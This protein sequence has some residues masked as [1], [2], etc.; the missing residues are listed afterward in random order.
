MARDKIGRNEPCPCGSGLKYKRCCLQTEQPED[1]AKSL[2]MDLREEIHEAMAGDEPADLEQAQA[3]LNEIMEA[4]N[5]RPVDDFHGLSPVQMGRIL[6]APFDSPDLIQITRPL[7]DTPQAPILTLFASIAEAIGERGLKPTAKGN[8]PRQVCRDALQAFT[9]A[10][11]EDETPRFGQLGRE[12]DFPELHVTRVAAEVGG[13]IRKHNRRFILSRHAR[14]VLRDEGLPGIYPELFRAYAEQFNWA[15]QDGY[16]SLPTVQYAGFFMLYLLS[17]YGDDW[18]PG[19]FYSDAFLTAFPMVMDELDRD[20]P[21]DTPEGYVARCV[22]LRA[23]ERF[24]EFLGLA[25]TRHAAG[26]P[27]DILPVREVRKT[28]LLDGFICFNV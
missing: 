22:R 17:Q 4:R 15:Y 1:H 14:A 13:L 9:D 6:N 16:P 5:S 28:P 19:R 3:R 7:P 18:R 23:L 24:A 27:D 26:G 20:P 21:F 2:R 10:G 8:L 25:E 11:Y 12:G